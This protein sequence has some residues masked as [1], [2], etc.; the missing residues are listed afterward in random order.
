MASWSKQWAE[1]LNDLLSSYENVLE[2]IE[3]LLSWLGGAE[4]SLNTA[5]LSPLPDDHDLVDQL[6][7]QHQLLIDEMTSKQG[8]F[9]RIVRIFSSQSITSRRA[10]S[11]SKYTKRWRTSTP[12]LTTELNVSMSDIRNVKVRELVEKWKIVWQM[13]ADRL[14]RLQEKSAY[15]NDMERTKNF[16][17][18]EWKK[19]FSG[20]VKNQHG[21]Q[22]D[23]YRKIDHSGSGRLTYD[24]FIEGFLNSKFPTCKA[25]ME[26]VA[27]IFDRNYLA[28]I[29]FT[30]LCLNGVDLIGSL[31]SRQ[32][33]HLHRPER[34]SGD[35]KNRLQAGLRR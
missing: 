6:I 10:A 7:K 30:V 19:R 22:L 34:V 16:S 12:N 14:R 9:E 5:E 1:K 33:R 24:D 18:D 23:F 11:T 4:N 27:P 2:L 3:A 15:L 21:K 25:E 26:K 8:D 32:L 29:F 35:P 20:W 28:I 31:S 13:C 17:F